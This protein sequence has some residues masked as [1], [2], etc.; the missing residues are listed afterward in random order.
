MNANCPLYRHH[1]SILTNNLQVYDRDLNI[2]IKE[3]NNYVLHAAKQCIPKGA[4]K[5]SK[6]YWNEDMNN[7]HNELTTA[8]NI[9]DVAPAIKNNTTLKQT[10][11]K[12]INT[13]NKDRRSSWMKKTGSLNMETV[14]NKLWR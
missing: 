7:K 2:V 8:I 6:S 13:R 9:A 12:F 11:A 5:D 14:G 1:T 4:R 10:N 3:F